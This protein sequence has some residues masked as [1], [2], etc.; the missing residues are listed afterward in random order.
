MA[1][2]EEL[3][4]DLAWTPAR[5]FLYLGPLQGD[6]QFCWHR[7]AAAYRFLERV[8]RLAQNPRVEQHRSLR[9]LQLLESAVQMR[10][11]QKKPPHTALAAVMGGFLKGKKDAGF[12]GSCGCGGPFETLCALSGGGHAQ[13]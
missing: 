3:V 11:Q 5:L 12:P 6:Y 4:V 10:L 9:E 2:F 1:C 7:L 8:W 13:M